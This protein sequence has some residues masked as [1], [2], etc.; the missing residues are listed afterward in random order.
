MSEPV[1]EPSLAREPGR[2]DWEK[3]IKDAQVQLPTVTSPALT[4]AAAR[5]AELVAKF[6]AANHREG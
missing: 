2:P 6:T 1:P 3:A 4:A 5:R